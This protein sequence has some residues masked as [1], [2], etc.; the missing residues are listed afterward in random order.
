[1]SFF[2]LD[3]VEAAVRASWARDTCD[4][5]DV[6]D[7][8]PRNP[9]RGQC[10]ATTLVLHDLFGGD[11][12]DAEV[13]DG[14]RLQGHHSWLRTSGGVDIDLTRQQFT[15]SEIVGAPKIYARPRRRPRRCIEQYELLRRRVFGRLGLDS[16]VTDPEPAG[17]AISAVAPLE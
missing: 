8:S 12:A 11:I 14:D 3:D 10:G 2:T 9:A 15:M 4:D 17:S 7:W 6:A 1:M 16:A 13:R 5:E